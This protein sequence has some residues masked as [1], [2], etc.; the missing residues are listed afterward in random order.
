MGEIVELWS[1]GSFRAMF[2]IEE[3]Q[4]LVERLEDYDR[5]ERAHLSLCRDWERIWD[6]DASDPL[7]VEEEHLR[8]LSDPELLARWH[9]VAWNDPAVDLIAG[10]MERRN[11]DA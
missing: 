8:L 9:K 5:A 10:E 3:W 6:V 7:E 4:R 11:L 1:V 2:L